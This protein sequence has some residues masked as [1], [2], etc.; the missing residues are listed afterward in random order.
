[1]NRSIHDFN[2]HLRQEASATAPA[3]A[4]PA[5][6]TQPGQSDE[7]MRRLQAASGDDSALLALLHEPLPLEVKLGAVAALASES[8]LKAAEIQLRDRDRR[9]HRLAKQ[10]HALAVARREEAAKA[11]KVIEAARALSAQPEIPLN[12]LVDVDHAWKALAV[13]LLGE[14]Q[15]AE[16]ESV[17]AEMAAQ[18]RARAD[19]PLK[20][21]R[22]SEQARAA[23]AALNSACA[24]AAAGT[25]G[26]EE[27]E[28]AGQTM[29]GLI[30]SAPPDV[31]DTA[32]FAGL[33]PADD[34]RVRLS[35]R[36]ALLDELLATSPA[37]VQGGDAVSSDHTNPTPRPAMQRW[38]ALPP[39]EDAEIEAALQQR[40]LSWQQSLDEARAARRTQ[41]R[42]QVRERQRAARDQRVQ[43]LAS[44]LELAESALDA[45]HLAQTHDHLLEIDRLLDG[46][47]SA[48]AL[49]ARIDGLQARYSQLKGWQHWA[50]GRARDDLVHQAEALAAA[51]GHATDVDGLKL[52]TRQLAEVIDDLRV[53]WKELDRL[54]GATSKSLWQRFDGALK[55]A[56][57]PVAAQVSALKAAREQNLQ[58]RQQILADL[59]AVTLPDQVE[60][61]PAPDWRMLAGALDHFSTAWRRMGPVEHT[62]P[63]KARASLL[64]RWESA[65]QRVEAPLQDARRTAALRRERL[66]TQARSLLA[67]AHGRDLVQ[68]VRDLQ[69]HW[70]HEARTLPLARQDENAMWDA[71]KS[72]ID[73]AFAARDEAFNARDTE[74]KAFGAERAALIDRLEALG[75]DTPAAQL[76][77]A[78]ADA[79][80]QWTRVGPAPR[81]DAAA[82]DARFRRA[83]DAARAWLA[84]SA[85]RT[86]HGIC[87]ALETKMALCETIESST[88]AAAAREVAA[89]RWAELPA[90]AAEWEAA[91]LRRA[92]LPT[93][94]GKGG[95]PPLAVNTDELMLQVEAGWGMPSPPSFEGAR[96]ALKLLAMKAALETRRPAQAPITPEQALAELMRRPGLDD[97]Q[98]GRLAAICAELRRRG[99]RTAG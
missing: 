31:L 62:V 25:I 15:L 34:L 16:Y 71:F 8:A 66:V 78:L 43:T 30:A 40:V 86:W 70:Q 35:E 29:R 19:Q 88:D 60:G 69:A 87:D 47:A 72:A 99:P 54:G 51:A 84:D 56:Y 22:W 2:P 12:H 89:A 58:G 24:A 14:A 82:L 52:G 32:L 97:M 75:P 79:E 64:A 5:M 92:G 17:M 91:L 50:G 57:E 41:R 90:L 7:A 39:L 46:G 53:R 28:A 49:R 11:A 85:Q 98:R 74:F 1:M 63:H 76:R 67:Q 10:R 81:A 93:P 48:A 3:A 61:A 20:L 42:E 73:A 13:D 27:L 83:R 38:A 77:R 36:L 80:G 9:V 33:A 59:Q 26:R 37:A 95:A 45:G 65:M 23:R 4:D 6:P 18:M 96:Q 44:V 94:V 68:K 21:R 55:T